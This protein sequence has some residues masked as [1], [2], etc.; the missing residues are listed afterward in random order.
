M[1]LAI[2]KGIYSTPAPVGTDITATL[3]GSAYTLFAG[4]YTAPNF[5]AGDP[6]YITSGG[7]ITVGSDAH[8]TSEVGYAITEAYAAARAAGYDRV[9]LPLGS[10]ERRWIEL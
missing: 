4:K 10:G 5:Q 8:S 6:A 9:A 2:R 3:S 7:R 1:G